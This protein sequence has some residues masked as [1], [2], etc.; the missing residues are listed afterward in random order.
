MM[1]TL[2][3]TILS[4]LLMG[5]SVSAQELGTPPPATPVA[6]P[7]LAQAL[8]ATVNKVE[9][10]ELPPD[11]IVPSDEGFVSIEA[12]CSG[13]IKWLVISTV[14]V[15]FVPNDTINSIIVSVPATPGAVVTVFAVGA[16]DGK[17][18]EFVRTVIQ[19]GGRPIPVPVDPTPGPGPTPPTVKGNFHLTF[20]VDL[21]NASPELAAVLNSATLRK[22]V[23]DKQGYLRVYDKTS[24]V[25][26]QKKLDIYVQKAGGGPTMILQA[27]DGTVV[28]VQAI[29]KSERE[30]IEIINQKVR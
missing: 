25:I 4:L 30:V 13:K 1:K 20:V 10:I 7:D 15:K 9:G 12:K 2:A 21:N 24:A 29:P 22:L 16:V 26:A 27:G 8:N 18:T 19:V 5:A 6:S 28:A 14:K 17:L 11:Q 23:T 3:A